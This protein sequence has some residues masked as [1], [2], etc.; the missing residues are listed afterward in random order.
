MTVMDGR[1]RARFAAFGTYGFI[2]VRRTEILDEAL[3]LASIVVADVDATCSRFRA[4]SDLSRVNRQ[5]GEWVEVHPLLVEAVRVAYDAASCSDGVVDPLLGRS[6]VTL[7]YDKDFAELVELDRRL[8]EAPL[9]P[10][11]GSWRQIGLDD[12]RVRIP[13][14]TALDLGA[15]AKAWAADLVAKAVET[16]LGQPAVVSLGGDIAIA[17]PDGSPWAVAVAERP[18][19]APDVVVDVCEGGLATSSTTVR[20][21]IHGGAARHH[22]LDPRTGLPAAEVWRTVTATGP[23]CVSANTASTAA[24]VLGE[25]A[26]TW[27][28]AH[29]VT[30]RLVAADGR[31]T[32]VGGWPVDAERKAA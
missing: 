4:D 28:A 30:A 29:G 5:P 15:T 21:W 8:T 3:R 23:S 17:S 13:A 7:G 9:A 22:L 1:T 27:L 24:V 6:L 14:G 12:G 31:V 11:A 25:R 18:G 2:A 26:P 19:A 10:S 32:G 20:R 16:E